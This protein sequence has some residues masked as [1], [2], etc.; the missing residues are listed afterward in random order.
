MTKHSRE[1]VFNQRVFHEMRKQAILYSTVMS[2]HLASPKEPRSRGVQDLSFEQCP[3]FSGAMDP[4]TADRATE[5]VSGLYTIWF[6][7][8]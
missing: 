8:C 1:T 2:P 6:T 4:E 3:F 7:L 5:V